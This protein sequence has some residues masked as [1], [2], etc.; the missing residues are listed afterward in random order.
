MVKEG[1]KDCLEMC[2]V[3]KISSVCVWV[4]ISLLPERLFWLE[5]VLTD[6][7]VW[8]SGDSPVLAV[9]GT[10]VFVQK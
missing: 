9:G 8:D 1:K 4:M 10:L 7:V 3:R 6:T 5:S 2:S